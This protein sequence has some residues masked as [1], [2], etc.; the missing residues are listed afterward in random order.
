MRQ[1]VLLLYF[2]THLEKR[3]LSVRT[4]IIEPADGQRIL[5]LIVLPVGS[6]YL[7]LS[8]FSQQKEKLRVECRE[9]ERAKKNR[10]NVPDT[11][12]KKEKKDQSSGLKVIPRIR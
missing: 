12:A 2:S 11:R 1:I 7:S 6:L 3:S 4:G 5:R 10:K 8:L 9:R